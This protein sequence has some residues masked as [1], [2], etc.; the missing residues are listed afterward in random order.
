MF[1]DGEWVLE[2]EGR[3]SLRCC[4]ELKRGLLLGL[5][6]GGVRGT[7]GR[8]IAGGCEREDERLRL[9]MSILKV[10]AQVGGECEFV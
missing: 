6:A 4:G 5:S 1:A 2:K 8:V 10:S 3:L 7:D 9:G